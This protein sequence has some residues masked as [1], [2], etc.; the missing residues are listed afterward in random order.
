[1]R[2]DDVLEQ[3]GVFLKAVERVLARCVGHS[4]VAP[5]VDGV[6]VAVADRGG[7]GHESRAG[8]QVAADLGGHETLRRFP[9][10]AEQL[11]PLL[12]RHVRVDLK[13]RLDQ[14]QD[15]GLRVVNDE[16]PPLDDRYVPANGHVLT[17]WV[18]AGSRVTP[19]PASLFVIGAEILP[20]DPSKQFEFSVP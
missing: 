20:L 14:G 12:V 11:D 2:G 17:A 3:P 10:Q 16:S 13:Q 19:E 4:V 1:M 9:G 5:G 6:H 18:M 15:D 8:A 7:G